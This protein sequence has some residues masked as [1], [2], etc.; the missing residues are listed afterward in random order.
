MSL[1]FHLTLDI[2]SICGERRDGVFVTLEVCN[3]HF[4]FRGEVLMGAVTQSF[5]CEEG[6][7][8]LPVVPIICWTTWIYKLS[9]LPG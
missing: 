4:C 8:L 6:D 9:F 1:R 3:T 2:A 7:I 5:L